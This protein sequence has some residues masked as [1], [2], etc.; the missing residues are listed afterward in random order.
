ML[1]RPLP[2][3]RRL[4]LVLRLILRLQHLP[5]LLLRPHSRP[6]NSNGLVG[7]LL[8]QH[9]LSLSFLQLMPSPRQPLL[10]EV[11]LLHL[12]P[13]VQL[14]S[15][16]LASCLLELLQLLPIRIDLARLFTPRPLRQHRFWPFWPW[17]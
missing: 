8:Q 4:R 3:R 11:K 12:L 6:R 5:V 14:Q 7:C 13:Q 2:S 9:C 16:M 15:F 1:H 17:S 10:L